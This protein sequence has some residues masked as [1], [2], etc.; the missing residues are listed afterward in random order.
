MTLQIL[1]VDDGVEWREIIKEIL[2]DQDVNLTTYASLKDAQTDATTYDWYLID[3]TIGAS[4]D[5]YRWAQQLANEGKNVVVIS[6]DEDIN[7]LKHLPKPFPTTKLL[8]LLGL[9]LSI[10]ALLVKFL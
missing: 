1:H 7:F 2:A 10:I 8:K 3:G 4:G 5:G 9:T 6:A